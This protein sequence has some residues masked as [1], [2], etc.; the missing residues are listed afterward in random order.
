MMRVVHFPQ[1]ELVRVKREDDWLIIR[2]GWHGR[3]RRALRLC[4][5][6]TRWRKS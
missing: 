1:R 4:A 2:N 5:K 6:P 3:T